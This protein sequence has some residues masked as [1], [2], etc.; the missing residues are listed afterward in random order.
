MMKIKPIYNVGEFPYWPNKIKVG[1]GA[2]KS[3]VDDI[4]TYGGTK[5]VFVTDKNIIDL[6]E[7]QELINLLRSAG[8]K[9]Y[10]YDDV[11][12]NPSD[13]C[14]DKAAAYMNQI[15][16]DAVIYYGGGSVIDLGKAA[17]LIYTHG[18]KINEYEDLIGGIEKI[19]GILIPSIAIPT[20][21]G[22]GSEVS[23]VSVITDSK[24]RVKMGVLSPYIV[25]QIS[26]L[27]AEVTVAMPSDLTA[28]TGMDALTHCIEAYVSNI[29][30]E[31]GRGI[32]YQGIKL[33][34][35]Y[36]YRAVSCGEDLVARENML[37]ASAC[38]SMAFNNNYLGT[39]HAC[40]HQLSS[41][42]G[43]PHGLANAVMLLPVMKWNL[44][45]N[46]QGYAE[47]AQALG[48]DIY[49]ITPEEAA[50]RAICEIEKLEALINIPRHLSD[51]GVTEEMLDELVN[52]AYNDHN[53]L[54]NPR[55]D[56]VFPNPVSKETIKK[57]FY[58]VL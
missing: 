27:D 10:I 1:V 40:A 19:K 30:F 50:E 54:S 14:V 21:A 34:K 2:R 17:N 38:G 18:G 47:V 36:L 48:V 43:I 5:V 32:A 52:K 11:E 35:Q 33:V 39:V 53:N 9:I 8:N 26:I 44:E 29:C 46:I 15:K 55:A 20:T 56:G 57:L 45:S 23:S 49:Q 12:E 31:P 3:I 51:I 25:P 37:V 24:R 16:P 22:S 42:V 28:Y 6:Y 41:T 13:I 58:E 7:T 4:K